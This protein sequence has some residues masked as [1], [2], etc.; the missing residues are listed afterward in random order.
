M[1]TDIST[2]ARTCIPPHGVL[3]DHHLPFVLADHTTTTAEALHAVRGNVAFNIIR[4]SDSGPLYCSQD[5]LKP[6]SH[7]EEAASTVTAFVSQEVGRIMTLGFARE[8]IHCL[9]IDQARA[10]NTSAACGARFAEAVL[11][12]WINVGVGMGDLPWA[13]GALAS[14]GTLQ[15]GRIADVWHYYH[16]LLWLLCNF[17]LKLVGFGM[18]M[19]VLYRRQRWSRLYCARQIR[20][21]ETRGWGGSYS[22]LLAVDV[23]CILLQFLLLAAAIPSGLR[24]VRGVH[25]VRCMCMRFLLCDYIRM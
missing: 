9:P 16:G 3:P 8:A 17:L 15:S 4:F 13:V 23:R 20:S 10:E 19:M 5:P 24:I 22:T 2:Q 6:A 11:P 7:G 12:V 25:L 1:R 14:I 21:G 18:G